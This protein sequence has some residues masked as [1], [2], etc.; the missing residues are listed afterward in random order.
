MNLKT[1]E[2]THITIEVAAQ[3]THEEVSVIICLQLKIF[4]NKYYFMIILLIDHIFQDFRE[5]IYMYVQDDF[6]FKNNIFIKMFHFI[7]NFSLFKENY[8]FA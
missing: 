4:I 8:L 2:L 5:H 7:I 6:I 3:G 1:K